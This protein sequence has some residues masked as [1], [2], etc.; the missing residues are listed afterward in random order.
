MEV[1]IG[2]YPSDENGLEER[3]VSVKIDDSDV[4]SMDHTLS[5]V[6]LPMLKKIQETKQGAPHVDDEDVPDELKS[7]SAPPVNRSN[8]ETDDNWFMRW[9]HVLERMIYSFERVVDDSWEDEFFH[10]ESGFNIEGWKEENE[11]IQRGL[12]LFG[13]YY[14]GLWT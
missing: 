13:K 12:V 3:E 6:I 5:Y 1:K 9:D 2:P 4:W 14:R 7:T 10:G 11:K 8:G